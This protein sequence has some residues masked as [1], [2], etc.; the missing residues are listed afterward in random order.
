[1]SSGGDRAVIAA[2]TAPGELMQI[3]AR[4][5]VLSGGQVAGIVGNDEINEE[6]L[7]ALAHRVEHRGELP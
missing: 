1:M 6:N 5:L 7:L 4:V 2:S 3:A